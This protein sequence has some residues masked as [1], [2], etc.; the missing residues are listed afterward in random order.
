MGRGWKNISSRRQNYR[1]I[2]VLNMLENE[3]VMLQV[4]RT[5]GITRNE[6]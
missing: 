6:A 4:S 3:Q 1:D 5:W 2:R